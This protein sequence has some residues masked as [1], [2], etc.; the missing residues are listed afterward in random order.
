MLTVL[1][2]YT[3]EALSVKVA[4]RIKEEIEFITPAIKPAS[5]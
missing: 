2:E 4:T 3:R 5:C 1:D